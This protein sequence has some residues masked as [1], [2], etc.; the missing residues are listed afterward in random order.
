MPEISRFFG[1]VVQMYYGDHEPPH[2]H[3]RYGNTT[4]RVR[5]APVEVLDADMSPRALRLAVEW[6]I[7]H[8]AELL[9]NWRL[10][11]LGQSPLSIAPL[12]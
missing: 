11:R 1:I 8:Q 2:F 6:G 4:A 9:E 7:L 5:L 12:E 3:A 10:I